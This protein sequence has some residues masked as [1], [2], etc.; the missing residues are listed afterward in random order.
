MKSHYATEAQG[1]NKI[2]WARSRGLDPLKS[3]MLTW[4]LMAPTGDCDNILRWPRNGRT[5]LKRT[6]SPNSKKKHTGVCAPADTRGLEPS[7]SSG[8]P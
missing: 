8:W 4:T 6:D 1:A 5:L 3:C 7:P 2:L